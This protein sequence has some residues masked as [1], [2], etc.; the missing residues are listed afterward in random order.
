MEA[1]RQF[2]VGVKAK[3]EWSLM[4]KSLNRPDSE[5]EGDGLVWDGDVIVYDAEMSSDVNGTAWI[6]MEVL[7]PLV[8]RHGGRVDYLEGGIMKGVKDTE[9]EKLVEFGPMVSSTE[10]SSVGVNLSPADSR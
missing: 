4:L 1:L 3:E 9:L 6:L 7:M 2:V 5:D 8:S 10:E